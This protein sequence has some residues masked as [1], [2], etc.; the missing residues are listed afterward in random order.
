MTQCGRQTWCGGQTN[1]ILA[2][3]N[4]W[5]FLRFENIANCREFSVTHS[6]HTANYPSTR[7]HFLQFL[8]RVASDKNCFCIQHTVLGK[9]LLSD[10][11]GR[12]T[13]S[14]QRQRPFAGKPTFLLLQYN[15]RTQNCSDRIGECTLGKMS[16]VA[17]HNPPELIPVAGTIC[18]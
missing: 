12:Y 13:N 15:T 18:R 1:H 17:L 14:F 3:N 9:F 7:T 5:Q 6:P 4:Q 2:T 11:I 8:A 16:V 10:R